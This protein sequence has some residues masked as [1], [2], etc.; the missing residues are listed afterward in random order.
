MARN[1]TFELL[2]KLFKL[3]LW[4][5]LLF[6]F[7]KPHCAKKLLGTREIIQSNMI[8]TWMD[9]KSLKL[10][11]LFCVLS[12]QTMRSWERESY[13]EDSCLPQQ[14]GLV[15]WKKN[16]GLSD[17][18]NIKLLHFHFKR[19]LL[20]AMVVVLEA[21]T[22]SCIPICIVLVQNAMVQILV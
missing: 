10:S 11:V 22:S 12:S 9:C 14:R 18:F 6:I 15:W 7:Y 17:H 4:Q 19:W 2:S 8:G 13:V 1:S 16:Q 20:R 5:K 21:G 3:L